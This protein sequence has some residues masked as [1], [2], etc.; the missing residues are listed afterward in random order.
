MEI[1]VSLE[2]SHLFVISRRSSYFRTD[3]YVTLDGSRNLSGS[4]LPQPKARKLKEVSPGAS[5][6]ERHY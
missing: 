5:S 1:L 6:S 2:G 4:Q 3:C